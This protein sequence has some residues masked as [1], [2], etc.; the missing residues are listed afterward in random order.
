MAFCE[1]SSAFCLM[2]FRIPMGA[3]L[4]TKPGYCSSGQVVLICASTRSPIPL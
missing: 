2:F 1:R 3:L 4:T